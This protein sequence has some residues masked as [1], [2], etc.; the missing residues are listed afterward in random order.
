MQW[1]ELYQL[2]PMVGTQAHMKMVVA[3]KAMEG[4]VVA[5]LNIRESIIPCVLDTND[6]DLEHQ[7]PKGF[8]SRRIG[9]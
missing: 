7:Y 8:N 6:L 5:M 4:F 2:G 3:N 1:V 9:E